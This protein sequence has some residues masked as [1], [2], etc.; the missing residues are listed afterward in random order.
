[1]ILYRQTLCIEFRTDPIGKGV[2]LGGGGGGD[3]N[4]LQTQ[5]CALIF[6]EIVVPELECVSVVHC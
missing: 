6:G 1:M 4:W 2:C 3:W 5:D